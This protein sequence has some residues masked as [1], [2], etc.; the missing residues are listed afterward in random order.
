[1]LNVQITPQLS[2]IAGFRFALPRHTRLLLLRSA[3]GGGRQRRRDSA[4]RI[5]FRGFREQL[6]R[7]KS[8]AL[9]RVIVPDRAQRIARSSFV[10]SWSMDPRRS[11]SERWG[12]ELYLPA[13]PSFCCG[14]WSDRKLLAGKGT[15]F[16]GRST[17]SSAS[18]TGMTLRC[19]GLPLRVDRVPRSGTDFMVSPRHL[20]DS[21]HA[22][23]PPK[24]ADVLLRRCRPSFRC[25]FLQC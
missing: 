7:R 14:L 18:L 1:M 12:P 11:S 8:T 16:A 10:P 3:A 24:F 19:R 22:A 6:L 9:S 23:P 13:R 5:L 25:W 21:R 17:S 20:T 15:D 2:R 4:S